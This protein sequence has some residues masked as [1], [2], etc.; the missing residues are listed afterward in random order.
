VS[1]PRLR[2]GTPAD[3]L[4]AE[5]EAATRTYVDGATGVEVVSHHI[6][7][8]QLRPSSQYTYEVLHD[9]AAP[10]AGTFRTGPAGRVPFRFTSFG[11]QGT[12][13][14]SDVVS[15]P[16]GAAVVDQVERMDPLLHLLNGD[17]CYAN[18][19]DDR[20]GAWR[21]FFTNNSRSARNR[22]WMPAA[23]A[24]VGHQGRA[25]PMGLRIL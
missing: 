2:L 4:G 19:N 20:T 8:D 13:V 5:I 14:T 11:D 10:V 6:T 7:L 16:M 25:V 21:R 1:R 18:V 23:G 15:S 3:G 9:G 17:L 12:G 22:P 24:V